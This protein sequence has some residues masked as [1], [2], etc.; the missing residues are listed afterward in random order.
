MSFNK[1]KIGDVLI[2]TEEYYKNNLEHAIWVVKDIRL[3]WFDIVLEWSS[4]EEEFDK[5]NT[6]FQPGYSMSFLI[7]VYERYFVNIS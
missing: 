6:R 4:R 1:I 3:A 2:S 7:E 5:N